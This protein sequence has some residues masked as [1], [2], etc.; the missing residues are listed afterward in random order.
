MTPNSQNPSPQLSER[1]DRTAIRTVFESSGRVHVP[2][3]FTTQSATRTFHAL[4]SETPWQISLNSGERNVN[5]PLEQLRLTPP[6]DQVLLVDTVHRAATQGFQYLFASFPLFDLHLARQFPGH[7]LMRVCE[8]LNSSE[9]LQFAREAT[10]FDDIN[11]VDAQATL[12]RPGHFL[13]AHDDF[14]AGKERLAAY[15]LNFTPR[16]RV[17]WGGILQFIDVD[18]HVAEGFTPAFNA[19]N[20]LR[21]P[22]KHCVSYVTPTAEVGRYSITG[23]LRRS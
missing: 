16:W 3:I 18:G 15:V 11:L 1:L 9:F 12:F 20:L 5:L 17:D 13:T 21:V 4:E 22:Q 14:Q 2:G 6:A 8:F 23:W 7:Y 10:G 19:L